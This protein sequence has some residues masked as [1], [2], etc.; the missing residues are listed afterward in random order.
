MRGKRNPK[1]ACGHEV[2][3]RCSSRRCLACSKVQAGSTIVGGQVTVP[4]GAPCSST[5][6]SST[7]EVLRQLRRPR[8]GS[9]WQSAPMTRGRGTATRRRT[10][11]ARGVRGARHDRVPP[12]HQPPALR[13][14]ARAAHEHARRAAEPDAARGAEARAAAAAAAGAPPVDGAAVR[15]RPQPRPAGGGARGDAAGDGRDARDG[16]DARPLDG[17]PSTWRTPSYPRRAAPTPRR[18]RR[19]RR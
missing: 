7:R 5:T 12:V 17:C 6:R 8:G 14:P 11:P 15:P 13:L 1:P 18:P 19:C 10:S 16:G 3:G 4:A 2:K 9:T